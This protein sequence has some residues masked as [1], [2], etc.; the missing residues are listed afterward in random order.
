[1]IDSMGGGEMN[2]LVGNVI[3][4]SERVGATPTLSAKNQPT[5][6]VADA[7]TEFMAGSSVGEP[8]SRVGLCS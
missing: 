6:N 1:M 7:V 3:D 2:T 5:S 8:G 4:M